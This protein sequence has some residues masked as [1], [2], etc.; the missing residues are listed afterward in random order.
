[1]RG[2]E[3][4]RPEHHRERGRADAAA[5]QGREVQRA[6]GSRTRPLPSTHNLNLPG[7][8]L[9]ATEN[10]LG[11]SAEKEAGKLSRP[12]SGKPCVKD[13]RLDSTGDVR[14][15]LGSV[16]GVPGGR[17]SPEQH[18]QPH[19]PPRAPP[20]AGGDTCPFRRQPPLLSPPQVE[21]TQGKPVH[22][23][24]CPLCSPGDAAPWTP[25]V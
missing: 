21:I 23:G 19:S 5:R 12:G 20:S 25:W 15:A 7:V 22:T 16:F 24:D 9:H 2:S 8:T 6:E 3:S 10:L 11:T 17:A 4:K 14:K 18:S 13:R 1:M